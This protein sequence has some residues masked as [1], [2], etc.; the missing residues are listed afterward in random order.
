MKEFIIKNHTMI[1]FFLLLS[2]TIRTC[3][4]HNNTIKLKNKVET[5]LKPNANI[6]KVKDKKTDGKYRDN[7]V[8]WAVENTE[9]GKRK[10]QERID[11]GL[12][13]YNLLP[14]DILKSSE[15]VEK[16]KEQGYD[17]LYQDGELVI[18]NPDVLQIKKF[19]VEELNNK[20]ESGGELTLTSEQVEKKLDRK[21]HWWNDDVVTING[22]EYKKVFLK[23]E[24][25][26]EEFQ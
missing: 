11:N 12:S 23:P 21:L 25:K 15:A 24:Y 26:I 14:R 1:T 13:L 2:V 5:I 18:Y 6:F 8:E 4:T 20:Y 17:G 19:Y 3:A 22:S 10:V 16:L 9:V 7:F